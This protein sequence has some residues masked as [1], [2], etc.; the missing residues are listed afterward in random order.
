MLQLRMLAAMLRR[1]R[2]SELNELVPCH[3]SNP[4]SS[5]CVR[6]PMQAILLRRTKSSKL[7]GEPIVSLPARLQELLQPQFSPKVSSEG[8][9]LRGLRG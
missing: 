6:W 3:H 9:A 7:N 8:A 4:L 1:T 2:S 5:L